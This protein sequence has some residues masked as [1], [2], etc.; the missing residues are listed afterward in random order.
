MTIRLDMAI[1]DINMD[2]KDRDKF[3]RRSR[4]TRL[5]AAIELAD[6]SKLGNSL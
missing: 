3:N 1:Y 5:S 2:Y 4:V 6:V